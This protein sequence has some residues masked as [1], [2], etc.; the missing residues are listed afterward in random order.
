MLDQLRSDITSRLD[1]LLGEAD[2]LRRALVALDPRHRADPPSTASTPSARSRRGSRPTSL[3]T[4]KGPKR[5]AAPARRAST[6][7]RAPRSTKSKTS[8]TAPGATKTAVLAA[9]DNGDAMTAGE[10]AAATGIGQA[11][12]ST[13][14]SRLAK[15]GEVTKATR[16]YQANK[17]A[18]SPPPATR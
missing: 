13:T 12:V 11:T 1:D 14:L 17:P 8:R 5:T 3:S 9:L 15:T 7:A 10:V 18:T 6:P 16:G 4:T 2:K